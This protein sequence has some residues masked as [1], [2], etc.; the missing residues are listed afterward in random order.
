MSD[1]QVSDCWCV[2][3]F[4]VSSAS[5]APT[6]VWQSADVDLL[7]TGWWQ[8]AGVGEGWQCASECIMDKWIWARVSSL[9]TE[10]LP[11]SCWQRRA[12]TTRWS[13]TIDASYSPRLPHDLLTSPTPP[14]FQFTYLLHVQLCLQWPVS[15][16]FVSESLKLIFFREISVFWG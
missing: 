13:E 3:D 1:A 6:T 15:V 11:R 10:P 8:N 7:E 2:T 5:E 4:C 14:D 9:R 16:D 12:T